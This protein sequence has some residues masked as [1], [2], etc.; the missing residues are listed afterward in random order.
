MASL[1]EPLQPFKSAA[2]APKEPRHRFGGHGTER[3]VRGREMD[4]HSGSNKSS[5]KQPEKRAGRGAYNWGR[6]L[7]AESL[8]EIKEPR[9]ADAHAARRSSHRG[10]QAHG[11]DTAPSADNTADSSAAVESQEG[12]A[13]EETSGVSSEAAQT[14]SAAPAESAEEKTMTLEEYM[15]QLEKQRSQAAKRLQLRK[16]DESEETKQ[17]GIPCAKEGDEAH[18]KKVSAPHVLPEWRGA[19]GWR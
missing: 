10:R 4:R 19:A 5:V 11:D 16:L 2:G 13:T 15:A 14:T 7:D 12:V 1:L 6:P 8:D 3:P 17:P 9:N 18:P